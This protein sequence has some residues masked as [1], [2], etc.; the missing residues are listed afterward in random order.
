MKRLIV[1]YIHD[2][3]S[4]DVEVEVPN[5]DT[6]EDEQKAEAS[7]Y[8]QTLADNGQLDGPAATHEIIATPDGKQVLRRRRF[9]AM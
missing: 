5:S 9:S 1:S 4:R 3:R 8:V 7:H 6:A 2:G